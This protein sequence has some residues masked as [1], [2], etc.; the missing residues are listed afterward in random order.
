MIDKRK[1]RSSII[2]RLIGVLAVFILV[3]T[4]IEQSYC[5]GV[6]TIGEGYLSDFKEV[7]NLDLNQI[8][9]NGEKAAVTVGDSTVY[10]S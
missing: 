4:I 2:L 5:M 7:D 3:M 10:I 8:T 9:F 1:F 6:P